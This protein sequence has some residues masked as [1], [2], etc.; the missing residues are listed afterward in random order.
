MA[1]KFNSMIFYEIV[2]ILVN[3]DQELTDVLNEQNSELLTDFKEVFWRYLVKNKITIHHSR[4]HQRNIQC[5]IFHNKMSVCRL[6]AN[7]L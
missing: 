2:S 6:L 5:S 4:Q 3:I 1:Q 7:P